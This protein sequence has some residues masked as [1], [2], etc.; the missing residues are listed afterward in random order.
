MKHLIAFTLGCALAS[1]AWATT[2]IRSVEITKSVD[3]DL[4]SD[5][6]TGNAP[7]TYTALVWD[8]DDAA[9]AAAFGAMTHGTGEPH[10]LNVR[11]YLIAGTNAS[12]ATITITGSTGDDAATAGF[13]LSGSP[14]NLCFT[15]AS[16]S[17]K[18]GTLKLSATDGTSTD[19]TSSKPWTL[20]H[21][22]GT[23][24]VTDRRLFLEFDLESGAL[25]AKTFKADVYG[26]GLIFKDPGNMH[27][28]DYRTTCT[29]S[30]ISK[31]NPAH[32]IWSGCT[33]GLNPAAYM[34]IQLGNVTG[35]NE[36]DGVLVRCQPGGTFGASGN[37]DLYVDGGIDGVYNT[38]NG[39]C[40]SGATTSCVALNST[41][42][43]TFSGTV[44]AKTDW[45][46]YILQSGGLGPGCAECSRVGVKVVK[47][48]TPPTN[49]NG[50]A[51]SPV[52]P[53]IGTYFLSAQINYW[54]DDSD[55]GEFGNSGKIKP[56]WHN[57]WNDPL[58]R[59]APNEETCASFGV[60]LPSNF[61]SRD[62]DN[63]TSGAIE[64]FNLVDIANDPTTFF[65]IRLVGTDTVA[66]DHWYLDYDNGTG[67]SLVDLGA[68]TNDIGKWTYFTIHSRVG[69][70]GIL[71]V[72]KSI[73][74]VVS[75]NK[76]TDDKVFTRLNQPLGRNGAYARFHPRM[77]AHGWH[78]FAAPG[79][80]H[81]YM[82][83]DV[84]WE[85]FDE[86]RIT[87][88]VADGGTCADVHPFG[89]DVSAI[90]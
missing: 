40:R 8:V 67:R 60:F 76:R 24:P 73:D 79:K 30:S 41:T 29:V 25:K 53:L 12:T 90:N 83:S 59:I 66:V 88:F 43:G 84:M 48:I 35:M 4:H 86:I 22:G 45:Y 46:N 42:F 16:N 55:A 78:H 61:E 14:T 9:F 36:L 82:N 87:R 10:C 56:R 72:W 54:D 64:H 3:G 65:N 23:P 85:G 28:T 62:G 31:A 70:N 27:Q 69:S 37:C 18:S 39:V 34:G 51:S 50:A 33:G 13:T 68:V 44:S 32:M 21:S 89:I 15:S 26:H 2:P 52:T 81:G 80:T 11:Q 47:S 20:T 17:D 58:L 77:Y 75:G 1:G 7:P 6:P 5:F 57:M 63:T 38:N 49:A 74:P 71:E 19:V